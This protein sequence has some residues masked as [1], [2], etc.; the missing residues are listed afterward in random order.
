M[1]PQSQDSLVDLYDFFQNAPIGLHLVGPD[2]IIRRANRAELAMLGYDDDPDSYIGRHIAEFH[3]DQDAIENILETL[4]GGQPIEAR[5]A[6]LVHRDGTKVPVV[7]HSCPRMRDGDFVS[8][9]C[10]TFRDTRKAAQEPMVSGVDT[11]IRDKVRKLGESERTALYDEL[12]DFFENGPVALHIVGPDGR[13]IRANRAELKS[14]GYDNDPGAYIGHHIAEFHADQHVIEDMLTVLVRGDR[15]THHEARLVK[16]DGSQLP[17]FIYSSPRMDNNEFVNTRCFTFPAIAVTAREAKTLEW[18]RNE[19]DESFLSAPIT[20]SSPEQQSGRTAALR[21]LSGRKRLE[22]SLA[23]LARSSEVLSSSPDCRDTIPAIA[24]LVVPFL[25]DS[26]T[27]LV[28]H[29]PGVLEQAGSSHGASLDK[30]KLERCLADLA[31]QDKLS[32]SSGEEIVCLDLKESKSEETIDGLD[33]LRELGVG[34]LFYLSLTAYGWDVGKLVLARVVG[35]R[36]GHF[37]AADIALAKEL[38]RRIALA[39]SAQHLYQQKEEF[40]LGKA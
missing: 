15:L 28:A 8:T 32:G 25:A 2:G 40:R 10:F 30:A 20:A 7:I 19:S 39:V 31:R 5:E 27:V 23:L 35:N 14:M 18:P 1:D 34:S 13:I 26:C 6:E 22:E 3:A 33:S 4:L 38:G 11:T 9:R 29:E 16:S 36:S 24:S 21:Y 17:V 37:G 12:N